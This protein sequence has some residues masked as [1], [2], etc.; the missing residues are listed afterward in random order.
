MKD[1]EHERL[2]P[3]VEGWSREFME[4]A[5]RFERKPRRSLARRLLVPLIAVVALGSAGAAAAGIAD[6]FGGPDLP[7]YQGETHAYMDLSTGKPIRCPD[8]TLLTYTP[9]AGSTEYEDPKCRDGSIPAVYERQLEDLARFSQGAEFGSWAGEGPRFAF[10]LGSDPD[11][12][13]CSG[14]EADSPSCP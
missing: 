11:A 12:S 13:L 4:A 7:P 1:Q 3:S 14:T 10:E 2:L 5:E 8:G 6:R 9:P